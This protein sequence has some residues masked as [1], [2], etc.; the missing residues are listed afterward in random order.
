[1]DYT[2]PEYHLDDQ[3]AFLFFAEYTPL[4][5]HLD[6]QYYFNIFAATHHWNTTWVTNIAY[7]FS[8]TYT[9][10]IPLE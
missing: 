10:G 5:Y 6:E 1:M 3:I 7:S 8:W 4:E 9:T 2:P